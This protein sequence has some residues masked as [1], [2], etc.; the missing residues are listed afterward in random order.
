MKAI[1]SLMILWGA[2]QAQAGTTAPEESFMTLVEQNEYITE[3]AK[4]IRRGMWRSGH[5]DVSS[6][7]EWMSR[8]ALTKYFDPNQDFPYEDELDSEEITDL[9]VCNAKKNCEVYLISVSGSYWGGYG[10]ES[11]FVML[12]TQS[13]KSYTHSHLVYSE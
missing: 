4:D 7:T 10:V 3:K 9:F 2:L 11:N 1:L 5:E 12:Y 8:E 13:K 6:S